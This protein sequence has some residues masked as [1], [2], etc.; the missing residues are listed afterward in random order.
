MNERQKSVSE[1][2]V[3]HSDASELLDASEEALD[4]IA[5]LVDM[6]LHGIAG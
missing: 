6:I 5:A 1:F 4:Q 2:V 3:A